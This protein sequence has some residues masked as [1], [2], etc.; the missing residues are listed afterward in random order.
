MKLLFD[1]TFRR[2]WSHVAAEVLRRNAIP[3]AELP[4]SLDSLLILDR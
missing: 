4:G 2:S 1:E 3:I